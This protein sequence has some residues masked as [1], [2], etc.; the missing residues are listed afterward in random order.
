VGVDLEPCV[1]AHGHDVELIMKLLAKIIPLGIS[2]SYI[3]DLVLII[4]VPTVIVLLLS[5]FPDKY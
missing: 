3:W 5:H 2:L 1:H 4:M